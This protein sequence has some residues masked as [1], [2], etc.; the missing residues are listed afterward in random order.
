MILDRIRSPLGRARLGFALPCPAATK[1][2]FARPKSGLLIEEHDR[3]TECTRY[4]CIGFGMRGEAANVTAI[5]LEI[6]M[7][8]LPQAINESAGK[9]QRVTPLG[10][11]RCVEEAAAHLVEL[12]AELIEFGWQQLEPEIRARPLPLT[13]SD[14]F[15][16]IN[17]IFTIDVDCNSALD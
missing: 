6:D 9:L 15:D 17:F 10:T 13:L 16:H 4:Y 5:P 1:I 12:A 2:E 14:R 8:L 3:F 7:G 11:S